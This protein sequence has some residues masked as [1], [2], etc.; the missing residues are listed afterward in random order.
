MVKLIG[1]S[2]SLRRGSF[3]SAVLRA[4]AAV[5]PA[6]SE[7][8]IEAIAGIPLY[9]GDDEAASGVPASVTRIRDAIADA[10]GFLLVKPEY[11]NSVPGVTKNAIDWLARPPADIRRVFGGKA[12]AL[13]GASPGGF[14][15]FM[16]GFVDYV[17]MSL[18]GRV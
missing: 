18:R 2:G 12:V 8:R 16:K 1:L 13:A 9:N 17:E 14:T 6:G 11:N 10:D 7:L 15:K 3:N 5:M 4:A